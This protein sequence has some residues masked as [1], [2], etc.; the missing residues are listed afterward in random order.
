[1]K[2]VSYLMKNQH[3]QRDDPM[4][5]CQVDR[6][7][8]CTRCGSINI[9]IEGDTIACNDCNAILCFEHE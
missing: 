3:K 7:K 6:I 2:K 5:H 8:I 4:K 9:K 1:M